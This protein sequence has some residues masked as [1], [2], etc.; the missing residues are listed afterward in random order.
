M[1]KSI[2]VTSVDR[3]SA[4]RLEKPWQLRRSCKTKDIRTESFKS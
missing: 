4:L 2:D 3:Q 1:V